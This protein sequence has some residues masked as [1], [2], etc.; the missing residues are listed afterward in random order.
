MSALD[1]SLL[2]SLP[3]LTAPQP[4]WQDNRG[5]PEVPASFLRDRGGAVYNNPTPAVRAHRQ[6]KPVRAAS[7]NLYGLRAFRNEVPDNSGWSDRDHKWHVPQ[8]PYSPACAQTDNKLTF[9]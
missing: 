1:P 9:N 5:F 8:F 2:V 7:T 6:H 4:T 3:P